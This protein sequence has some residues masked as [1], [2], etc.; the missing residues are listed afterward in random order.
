[1]KGSPITVDVQPKPWARIALAGGDGEAF[2]HEPFD[3]PVETINVKPEQL[4]VKIADP[5][6]KNVSDVKVT[7][8]K[9]KEGY[10]VNFTPQ[11]PG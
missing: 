6:G 10:T 1:M 3:F 8:M 5:S 7:P 2:V 4:S 11:V 9:G